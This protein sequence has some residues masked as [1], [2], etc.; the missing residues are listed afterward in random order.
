MGYILIIVV[1]CSFIYISIE[2]EID[3]DHRATLEVSCKPYSLTEHMY[4]LENTQLNDFYG[5]VTFF[6]GIHLTEFHR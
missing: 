6:R 1:Y 3:D 4:L 2:D 5:Y